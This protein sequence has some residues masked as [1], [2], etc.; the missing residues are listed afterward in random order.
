MLSQKTRCARKALLELAVLLAG[1]T[2]SCAHSR[3]G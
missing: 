1:D 3:L 2:L